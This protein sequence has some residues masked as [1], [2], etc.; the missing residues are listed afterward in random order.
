MRCMLTFWC[1][2]CDR[3]LIGEGA[4]DFSVENDNELV[5][6]GESLWKWRTVEDEL[7]AQ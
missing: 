7:R 3:V 2:A 6:P 5:N 1:C 4:L